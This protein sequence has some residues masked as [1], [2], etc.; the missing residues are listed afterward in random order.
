MTA[1]ERTD[2]GLTDSAAGCSC[3]STAS[4][5]DTQVAVSTTTQDVLVDGMTCS[6]CVMSVTEEI[7]AI[8]GVENVSVDLN[9]GGSSRVTIHSAAPIDAERVRA[10]VEEAGYALAGSPS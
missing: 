8:D 2:L 4:A 9:A 10:A 5:T 7:T 1:N 3:C 6:H